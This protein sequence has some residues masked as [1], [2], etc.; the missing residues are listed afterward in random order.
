VSGPERGLEPLQVGD[1]IEQRKHRRP[2]AHSG[3][4]RL[5]RGIEVV[6]LTG[7][8]H[9][10]PARA[11]LAGEQRP[12]GMAPEVARGALDCQ[13]V[14]LEMGL[15]ARSHEEGDFLGHAGLEQPSAEIAADRAG[16]EDQDTHRYLL[17]AVVAG[18]LSARGRC[19]ARRQGRPILPQVRSLGTA[20][21]AE[22]AF[23]PIVIH[24]VPKR[25]GGR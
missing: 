2:L 7:Q 6:G 3:T 23:L 18:G 16:A 21:S 4:G 14:A 12:H 1:A 19:R 9:H 25:A 22:V 11:H 8:Q 15:A 20:G 17:W 10:V 24:P 13:P 5:D